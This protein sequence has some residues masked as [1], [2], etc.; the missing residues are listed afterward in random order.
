MRVVIQRVREA[1]VEVDGE[2]IGRIGKTSETGETADASAAPGRSGGFLLLVG[3]GA[4]DTEATLD[5]MCDKVVNLRVLAD[6]E[7]KMN[8]SLLDA[9][10]E[11]LA[12]SQFTLYADCKKGRRPSFIRAA[13]PEMGARMFD[14]FVDKLRA[15]GLRVETGRFGAMMD[16][17]LVNDGPVTITLD[18]DELFKRAD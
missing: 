18:S 16:V 2:T 4:G 1:R 6:A 13:P 10:G 8:L 5:A 17:H 15:T 14:L 11:I 7:G 9:R 12:V 3:I